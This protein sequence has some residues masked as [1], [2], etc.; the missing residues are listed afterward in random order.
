ME[1]EQYMAEGQ[2]IENIAKRVKTVHRI[3]ILRCSDPNLW[4]SRLVGTWVDVE[5]VTTDGV[6]SRGDGGYR[7]FIRYNDV[8]PT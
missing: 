6:W 7:N 8:V 3:L 5:S 1:H 4:Y 2:R